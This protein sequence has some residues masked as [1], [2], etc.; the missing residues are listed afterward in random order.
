MHLADATT[1]VTT[2]SGDESKPRVE[3]RS[4]RGDIRVDDPRQRDSGTRRRSPHP[5]RRRLTTDGNRRWMPD[6]LYRRLR[7]AGQQH[8]PAFQGI[9][10]LT[11]SDSGSAR[12][13]VRLPSPAR[14]G[15]RRF[16]LHPVMVDIAL[17]ALGA[18]KAATDLA[19]D[20]NH[21][22]TVI[23]P[24]RLAGIRVYG[25]VTEGVCATG[26]LRATVAPGPLRRPGCADRAP[27]AGCC[28]RS[29][30]STWWC[31]RRR[32]PPTASPADC[33]P[34]NGSRWISASRRRT[35]MRCCWSVRHP[36]TIRCLPC[37]WPGW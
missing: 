18:T 21:G 15:S 32:E 30:R 5:S 14:Q 10:G 13:A 3:I 28:W 16:L 29:T 9:V 31:F 2:L 23:L 34:W 27:T 19:A 17:Q 33:S 20:E 37:C 1:V 22:P 35:S 8:G 4:R 36:R 7:S 12:A 24:V 26:S 6:E 11:V 25:D